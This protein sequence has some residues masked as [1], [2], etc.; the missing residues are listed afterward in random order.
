MTGVDDQRIGRAILVLRQRRGWRQIDL[1]ARADVSQSA[2]SDMERGRIDRYTIATVRRTLRA[3]D[4]SADLHPMWGG[5][6]GLDRLLDA[7][8]ARLMTIWAQRHARAGWVAWT[9]ASYNVYGERG[10][11]DML[12]FHA[13]TATLEVVEGKTGI[14]DLGDTLGRLDVKVRLAARI[15]ATRGWRPRKVV[16]ALVVAEGSTARRRVADHAALFADFS[17]RAP[18]VRAFIRDPRIPVNALLAFVP[19]PRT[20]QDGRRR[21]GQQRVRLSKGGP[22]VA[23]APTGQ[24]DEGEPA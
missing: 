18:T 5:P 12:A 13:P 15:A 23:P 8:H 22:S 10:R 16:A 17:T 20:N 9:E 1:A 7:D 21:A 2:I 6:G 3:L 4:T 24:T 14:W 19:L 11:I